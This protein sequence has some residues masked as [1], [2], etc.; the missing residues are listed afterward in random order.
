MKFKGIAGLLVVTFIVTGC[1]SIVGQSTFPLTINSN[2]T[3][4][5]ITVTD[6][7]GVTM[8][9]GATP[10]TV[11]LAAGESYFHA[12]S[13]NIIFTKAGYA[14]QH[15]VVRAE[16]S[17]WYFG[18]ILFGGLI[19]MLIVDPITG[20]MWKLPANTFGNL[21]EKTALNNKQHELQIAT[22]DQIPANM[23][24]NLVQIN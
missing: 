4:A 15:A 18:N 1:A 21:S 9:S 8:F 12:K 22:L 5:N 23:K 2:P 16:I 20:K 13:Y 10:T 3:G 6:E 19:G 14:E 24:K 11:T 17:G 7:H